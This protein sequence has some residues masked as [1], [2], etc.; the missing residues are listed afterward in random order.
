MDSMVRRPSPTCVLVLY[1]KADRVLI[2]LHIF[3][4]C[5]GD[6]IHILPYCVIWGGLFLLQAF[7][8]ILEGLVVEVFNGG[9]ETWQASVLKTRPEICSRAP[10]PQPH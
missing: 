6:K 4:S 2:N 10:A 1:D 5:A 7:P 3:Q 9:E 8:V